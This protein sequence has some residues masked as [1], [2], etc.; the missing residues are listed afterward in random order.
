MGSPV[1]PPV[2][3]KRVDGGRAAFRVSLSHNHQDGGGETGEGDITSD[4]TW[5]P[6]EDV[7]S[8]VP[9]PVNSKRVDGGRAA[10]TVSLS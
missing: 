7:N 2:N 6:E 8:P 5:R 9:P 4:G 1:P 3:S 10:F